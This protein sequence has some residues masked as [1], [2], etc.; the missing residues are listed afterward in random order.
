MAGWEDLEEV[1]PPLEP[2]RAADRALR[3]LRSLEVAEK[4]F[5]A[6]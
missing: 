1:K 6:Q 3:Y 4:H 2:S 5:D